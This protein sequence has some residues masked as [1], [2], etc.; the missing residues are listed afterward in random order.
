MP[1]LCP[2]L[3]SPRLLNHSSLS[4]GVGGKGERDVHP[5]EA[6][7]ASYS[8]FLSEIRIWHI[9]SLLFSYLLHILNYGSF[10]FLYS[11]NHSNCFQ[12]KPLLHKVKQVSITL[13]FLFVSTFHHCDKIPE[14]NYLK[15]GKV[16]FVSQ[17]QR[18]LLMVT[19]LHSF[20]AVTR[21]NI[22]VGSK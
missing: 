17:F 16:Y 19:W 4:D 5:L 8:Q 10:F 2:G 1:S 18:F 13:C 21:Q 20:W 3:W 14:R 9:A 6:K 12:W 22:M 7:L 15:G 11:D